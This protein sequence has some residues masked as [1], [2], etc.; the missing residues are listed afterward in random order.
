M[1]KKEWNEIKKKARALIKEAKRKGLPVKGKRNIQIVLRHLSLDRYFSSE[2]LNE[3][4]KTIGLEISQKETRRL[5]SFFPKELS[6]SEIL[7]MGKVRV[8]LAK[9]EKEKR[10]ILIQFPREVISGR[11]TVLF[12]LEFIKKLLDGVEE[13]SG[14][15]LFF[16]QFPSTEEVFSSQILIFNMEESN[17]ELEEEDKEVDEMMEF[18]AENEELLEEL[19]EGKKEDEISFYNDGEWDPEYW[20]L[21]K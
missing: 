15:C 5:N 8:F 3:I 2:R 7:A 17:Q 18:L 20:E 4:L 13:E 19:R 14:A 12:T 16:R 1:E 6:L 21:E 11:N 10:P 9:V